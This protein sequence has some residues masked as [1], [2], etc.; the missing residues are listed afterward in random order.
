MS[1]THSAA[2]LLTFLLLLSSAGAL[3]PTC[4]NGSRDRRGRGVVDLLDLEALVEELDVAV[5]ELLHCLGAGL[6]GH[7]EPLDP[8]GALHLRHHRV[9][10]EAPLLRLL[11]VVVYLANDISKFKLNDQISLP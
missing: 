6:D 4:T 7:G 9:I 2:A 8:G 3:I 5:G 11:C 10:P 1:S